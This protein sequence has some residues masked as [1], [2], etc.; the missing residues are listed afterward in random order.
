MKLVKCI[1]RPNRLEEVREA[2]SKLNVSG[3]TVS[4]VRGH[5]RQKGHKAIYRGREY[6]VTLLPK[7]MIEMVLPDDLV[8]EVSKGHHR[9]GSD[10]RN[11]GRQD[12][13]FAC[14]ARDTTFVQAEKDIT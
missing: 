11:W 8:D 2:L 12:L 10:R 6:S 1:I 3:M 4:E 7:M 14:G 9:D 13:R 5:G